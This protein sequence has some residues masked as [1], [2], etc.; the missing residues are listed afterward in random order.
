LIIPDVFCYNSLIIGLCK[1]KEMEEARTYLVEM[2][3]R[4]LEPNAYTYGAFVHGYSKSGE[5][6]DRYFS[7]MLGCGLVPNNV[8]YTAL[9]DGHCK[10]GNI[11]EAFSAFRCMLAR[12][13]FLIS[14]LTV[15]LLMVSQGMEKCKKLLRSSQSFVRRDQ[16]LMSS[17]TPLSLL[18]STSRV[19]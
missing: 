5:M 15:C 4:G 13:F 2:M 18:V 9:I 14:I 7:E 17:L 19:M 12:G 10:E 8:I 16:F 3:E 6:A 11:T 1:A